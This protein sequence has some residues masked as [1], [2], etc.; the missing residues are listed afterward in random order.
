MIFNAYLVFK[1][2]KVVGSMDKEVELEIVKTIDNGSCVS[3]YFS[4]L[5]NHC[6]LLKN[7]QMALGLANICSYA[8]ELV[9]NIK[10][11]TLCIFKTYVLVLNMDEIDIT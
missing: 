6:R 8:I 2:R 9:H 3:K 11:N 4:S 1:S 5:T 10:K 7:V